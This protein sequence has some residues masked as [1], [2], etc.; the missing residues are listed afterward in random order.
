MPLADSARASLSPPSQPLVAL[1]PSPSRRRTSPPGPSPLRPHSVC[2]PCALL[3]PHIYA[4]P[5]YVPG[6]HPSSCETMICSRIYMRFPPS[7]TAL[8]GTWLRKGGVSE[9]RFGGGGGHHDHGAGRQRRAV[10]GAVQCGGREGGASRR[11]RR[12]GQSSAP[13][14]AL[15]R[16]AAR[17]AATRLLGPAVV[18]RVAAAAARGLVLALLAVALVGPALEL[19]PRLAL[20]LVRDGAA[21]V[22]RRVAVK[23]GPVVGRLVARDGTVVRAGVKLGARLGLV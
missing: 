9:R 14:L 21:A 2:S 6:S 16:A 7:G 8:R 13:A 17:L 12:R 19:V 5:S 1:P 3:P 10:G 4:P 23:I 11:R 20:A 15:G 22:V 18:L